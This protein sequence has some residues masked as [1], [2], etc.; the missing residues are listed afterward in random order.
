MSKS[1]EGGIQVRTEGCVLVALD[2][3]SLACTLSIALARSGFAVVVVGDG[4]EA[5]ELLHDE[6]FDV[7]LSDLASPAMTGIQLLRVLRERAL[8]VPVVLIGRDPSFDAVTRAVELGALAC[9]IG[10]LEITEVIATTARAAQ[11]HRTA[12]IQRE[13]LGHWHASGECIGDCE[14]LERDFTSAS[15]TLWMAYQP[16]VS[17]SKQTIVAFEGLVRPTHPAL[18][19]AAALI[20]AA[21]R[22]GR[23]HQLGRRL[24]DMV[25]AEMIEA[26]ITHDVF[27]NIHSY[28]LADDHLLNPRATLSR[29]A[30]QVVLEITER[31][32]LETVEDLGLRIDRLR[33]LGFRIA[34]DD[35][36][37][38]YASLATFALLR[39]DIVKIDMSLVRNVDSEPT[40]ERLVKSIIDLCTDMNVAVVCEGIETPDERDT[41]V[42]LGCDLFQGHYFAPPGR[43]FPAVHF[44]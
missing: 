24:R 10:P 15:E 16:I 11:L 43:P 27:V 9:L 4:R 32:S 35:L 20:A 39:P 2:E 18:P 40:K 25:A 28:H 42:R 22:L 21:E 33:Q 41:L 23:V 30:P 19:H 14:G 1:H 26:V 36:G 17:W 8:A 37:A 29:I 34:L 31:A 5:S 12:H 13:S 44:H 38:G 3:P 6:R 7:V